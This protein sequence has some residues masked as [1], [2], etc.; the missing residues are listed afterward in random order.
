MLFT[1]VADDSGRQTTAV[2]RSLVSSGGVL[3]HSLSPSSISI[4]ISLAAAAP[5][6][7]R[8]PPASDKVL[9]LY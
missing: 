9:I 2:A 8:A 3:L 5:L 1:Y 4:S 7:S 6:T